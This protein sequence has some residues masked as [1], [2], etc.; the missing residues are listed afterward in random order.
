RLTLETDDRQLIY[1]TYKGLR[2]G[3]KEVIDSLNRGESIDP[4][5]YYFRSTPYFETSSQTYGW[6]NG[7]CAVATGSRSATGPT[8]HVFQVL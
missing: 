4:S 7:I 8:Y 5:L 2:H 3:P 6:L 1:M